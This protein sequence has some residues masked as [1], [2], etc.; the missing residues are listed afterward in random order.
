V[1]NGLIIRR[2]HDVAG[3]WVVV[4]GLVNQ[5]T[6]DKTIFAFFSGLFVPSADAPTATRLLSSIEYPGNHA[7]PREEDE[8][9][10][11]AGEIPWADTWRLRQYPAFIEFHSEE[12]Q[13]FVPVRGYGW[14]SYHSVENKLRNVCFPSKELAEALDLYVQIPAISMA[15]KRSNEIA[16]MSVLSGDDYQNR[17]SLVLL[18]QDLLNQYLER[19]DLQLILFVWGERRANYQ[20]L[21]LRIVRE[22]EGHFELRDILHKQGFV[23][24]GGEFTQFY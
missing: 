16:A 14:E 5:A 6:H 21:D 24:N 7:I 9:Y 12:L 10:T 4:D 2:F 13:V 18:R 17:E 1:A 20:T 23:Y 22:T 11:Y 8:H 3:P 15:Q 19:N